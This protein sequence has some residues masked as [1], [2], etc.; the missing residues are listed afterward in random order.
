MKI[1]FVHPDLGLGG[2]ERFIV[3]AALSLKDLNHSPTIYTPYQDPNR[4]FSEVKPPNQQINVKV[5]NPYVPRTIFGRFQALLCAIRCTIVALYVCLF[6]KVDVAIVDLVS[7]PVF[8]FAIFRKPVIFYCHY[9]DQLLAASLR[10]RVKPS[11]FKRVYRKI[12]DSIE[13]FSLSC[14][15]VV[16][17]NSRFT[18]SKFELTF[19]KLKSPV[20]IY[21]CVNSDSMTNV[22]RNP[23]LMLLSINRYERK[24]SISLAIETL[25]VLRHR[26]P[27][28]EELRLVIAGGYDDRLSTNVTYFEE[29][30]Q[31]VEARGL[32]ENVT[33]LR[34]ISEEHRLRL[35]QSALAVLYT[36]SDEHFGIV[37]LEA[38]AAGVPV[39]AVNSGGPMESIDD[40]K[41]GILCESSAHAFS[42]AITPLIQDTQQSIRMG[43]TGRKRVAKYFSLAVLG[44]E[45][46]NVLF[47][48]T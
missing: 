29:L 23:E 24:K 19:P 25:F 22:K 14:A 33:L 32:S 3:D 21:P 9:P 18:K 17:C 45:L 26:I 11:F 42:L 44:R 34:N 4:T 1:A 37:P 46:Q 15:N 12:V 35:Y 8:I 7:L 2:A 41:T 5:C 20:V 6:C 43:E 16:C 13:A 38:M 48:I 39:I 40:G 47:R 30:Q 10:H 28:A 27:N 31:L 36:P